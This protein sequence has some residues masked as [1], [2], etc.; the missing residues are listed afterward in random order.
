[1]EVQKFLKAPEETNDYLQWAYT[2]TYDMW[3]IR[4]WLGY[5]VADVNT[6]KP[7][8]QQ[9]QQKVSENF[10]LLDNIYA[11]QHGSIGTGHWEKED[12]QVYLRKSDIL[13]EGSIR[14]TFTLD[15][16][17]TKTVTDQFTFTDPQTGEEITL[18]SHDVLAFRISRKFKA[19]MNSV[20][21]VFL[22][23]TV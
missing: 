17:K 12:E 10:E 14:M 11:T 2:D 19:A 3:D 7:L 13:T 21:C 22:V 15:S 20:G 18:D 8:S 6:R 4:E 5:S 9:D 23:E 16:L 1:M